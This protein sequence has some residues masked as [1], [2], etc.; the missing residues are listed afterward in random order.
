MT[1]ESSPTARRRTASTRRRRVRAIGLGALGA[2]IVVIFGFTLWANSPYRADR[3]ATLEVFGNPAISVSTVDEGVLLEPVGDAAAT[4]EQVGLV[5]VPGARV[6]AWAYLYQ[7]SGIVEQSGVTV[8][9]TRPPLNLA[10]F[11]LR[12]LDE[13]TTAAP[14]V[15]RWFLAGHSLGGVRACLMAQDAEV[16]GV[17]LLG[18][19][20]ANDLSDTGLAVLSV[21]AENDGLT[22]L[23]T[24]SDTADLLPGDA[25]FEVIEGANHAAFGDYGPQSGDGERTIT[26]AQMREQLTALLAELVR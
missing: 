21:A 26:S 15:E 13:L 6:D 18:S 20:C 23:E 16:E 4:G 25:R 24:I 19:Y 5:V 2:L 1:S 9:I 11:D 3:T 14:G 12:G 7:M 10:F 8:L 22:E 17:V